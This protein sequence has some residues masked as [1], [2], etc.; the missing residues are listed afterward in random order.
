MKVRPKLFIKS[1]P[2][3]AVGVGLEDDAG[4]VRVDVRSHAAAAGRSDHPY[5]QVHVAKKQPLTVRRKFIL[6]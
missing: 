4:Q 2:D 5:L 6:F 1:A 3:G